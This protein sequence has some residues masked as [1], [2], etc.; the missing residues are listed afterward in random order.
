MS[1][2]LV[3]LAAAM[4]VTG[5]VVKG[6]LG[7]GLPLVVVPLLTLIIPAP[8]AMGLLVMPVLASNIWQA[9]QGGLWRISLRR[10]WPLMLAQAVATLLAVDWSRSWSG[11]ALDMAMGLTVLVAVAV[12]VLQPRGEVSRAQEKWLGPLIGAVAGAM[13]GVSSLTGPLLITYLL[14]LRL[15]REVFVGSIS[16]IYLLGALPMYGAMLVWGR[17][18][19]ESVAWSVLALVP[20]Y[21]GLK[22]GTRWREH[23]DE[24]QFRRALLALLLALGVML[25]VR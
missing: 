2:L 8:Q 3:A 22:L 12:M 19:W 17:F 21:A 6:T 4:F 24:V 18:G 14:A 11:K 9:I 5:G 15:P 25:L 20:V 1:L 10:F 23:L 7:V 13:A 16:I